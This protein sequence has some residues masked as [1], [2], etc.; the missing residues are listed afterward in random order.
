MC[1]ILITWAIKN[2][3]WSVKRNLSELFS[4]AQTP[5]NTNGFHRRLEAPCPSG[6]GIFQPYRQR[7]PR[8]RHERRHGLLPEPSLCVRSPPP[9]PPKAQSHISTVFSC[10]SHLS[11]NQSQT[12]QSGATHTRLSIKNNIDISS[13]QRASPRLLRSVR[14]NAGVAQN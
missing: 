11:H 12:P 1:S 7:P 4:L 2:V 3:S 8:L 13:C 10:F 6:P 14:C 5:K 9:V